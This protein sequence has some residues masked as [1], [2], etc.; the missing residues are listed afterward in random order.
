MCIEAPT[1][2]ALWGSRHAGAAPTTLKKRIKVLHDVLAD[3][4]YAEG[5]GEGGKHQQFFEGGA[6]TAAVEIAFAGWP[7]SSCVD[8]FRTSTCWA[9][10]VV[11]FV[12]ILRGGGVIQ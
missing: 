3:N 11:E 10:E 1:C 12:R 2:K 7:A 5:E 6:V 4:S 9:D 8:G